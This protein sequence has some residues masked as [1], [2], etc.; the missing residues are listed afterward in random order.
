MPEEPASPSSNPAP[1]PQQPEIPTNPVPQMP[2]AGQP[3]AVMPSQQMPAVKQK[4][5]IAAQILYALGFIGLIFGLL[6]VV[7]IFIGTSS[8]KLG[9]FGAGVKVVAAV[10][11]VLIIGMF[12]IINAIRGGKKWALI[13]Y[14]VLLALSVVNV[15]KSSGSKNSLAL[16]LIPVVLV[17]VLWTK[18]QD[19]FH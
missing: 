11:A 14:S 10:Y 19:Y 8:L 2:P 3:V 4:P 9:L 15:L 17:L 5:P 1:Q 7:L 18:N 16:D 6:F 13:T 12:Y